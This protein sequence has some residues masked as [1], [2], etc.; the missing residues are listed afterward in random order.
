MRKR[1]HSVFVC[2][3]VGRGRALGAGAP[4]PL[5]WVWPD[6]PP[7]FETTPFWGRGVW[8]RPHPFPEP[9][10]IQG[11]LVEHWTIGDMSG[12]QP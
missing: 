10:L 8:V 1:V 9:L 7:F 11:M 6:C 12:S 2:R 4:L 3:G 5:V